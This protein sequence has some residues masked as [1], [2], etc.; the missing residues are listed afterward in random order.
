MSGR[1]ECP[2]NIR[3]LEHARTENATVGLGQCVAAFLRRSTAASWYGCVALCVRETVCPDRFPKE[4]TTRNKHQKSMSESSQELSSGLH[5][6]TLF[7][8]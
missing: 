2:L 3:V 4:P 5:D 8:S 6:F 7:K 1:D